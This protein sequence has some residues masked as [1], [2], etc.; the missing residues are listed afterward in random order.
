MKLE[1]HIHIGRIKVFPTCFH[2][3]K[4]WGKDRSRHFHSHCLHQVNLLGKFLHLLKAH[5]WQQALPCLHSDLLETP[6]FNA[7]PRRHSM[8]IALI[9]VLFCMTSLTGN[10]LWL[11]VKGTSN[12]N[13]STHFSRVRF[14]MLLCAFSDVSQ[15]VTIGRRLSHK[16][17]TCRV[18][19]LC[20]F[21]GGH[22]GLTWWRRLSHM[23][24][25][26]KVSL[27]CD[28]SGG[29]WDRICENTV[30]HTHYIQRVSSLYDIAHVVWG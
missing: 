29:S 6:M 1:R 7:C 18:S 9:G 16:G 23:P 14:L 4:M 22:W 5:V 24:C 2:W 26:H 3:Q 28:F 21:F 13:E 20:E 12:L 17:C 19:L 15:G 27:P 30:F 10:D 8:E 25:T 11:P